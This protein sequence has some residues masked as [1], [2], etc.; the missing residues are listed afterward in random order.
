MLGVLV[1][2]AAAPLARIARVSLVEVSPS[3]EMELKD[4]L[5]ADLRRGCRA[6]GAIGA[7][8]QRM[9]SSV[10]MLGWIMPAPL[11]MPAREYVVPRW[12]EEGRVKVVD[13][14]LG[15]VSVVMMARAVVSQD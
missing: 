7:S 10:A 8:V 9:P 4:W 12:W 15:K 6:A 3:M 11:V 2:E 5:A 13:S 14:N 1:E